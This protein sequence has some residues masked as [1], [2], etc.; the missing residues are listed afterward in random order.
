M[1][2][3]HSGID[4]VLELNIPELWRERFFQASI[5]S[6]RLV[7]G[8]YATDWK[9]FLAAWEAEMQHLEAHRT[10]GNKPKLD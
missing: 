10:A 4:I 1:K 5:G 8:L 7:D 3:L 9:K 6:T 2:R